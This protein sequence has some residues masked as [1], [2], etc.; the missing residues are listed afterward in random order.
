MT[1]A[2]D[3]V[4]RS[5]VAADSPQLAEL[6][7][8]LWPESS[9]AEHQREL[10]AIFAGT[11]QTVLPMTIFV[12]EHRDGRVL[13][14]LEAGLRS[15]ADGCDPSE[16]VGYVEGW[17]VVES[18]RG[19]G[20]G[21]ALLSAAEDWARA[22]GCREMASDADIANTLSQRVHEASGFTAAGRSVLYRKP[23]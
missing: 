12:A 20:I 18:R 1:T 22:Q 13:G 10:Q 14:F 2:T 16:P 21:R 17:L 7:T 19:Q 11:F 6:R 8:A 15:C 4:V 5:A 3:F 23:L 9:S